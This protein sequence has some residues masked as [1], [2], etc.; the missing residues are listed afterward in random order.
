M[1]TFRPPNIDPALS[2]DAQQV[3]SAAAAKMDEWLTNAFKN[4]ETD[5]ASDLDDLQAKMQAEH[6][7]FIAEERKH[8]EAL[9]EQIKR[10]KSAGNNLTPL[11][12]EQ[13][14][15]MDQL[16]QLTTQAES[17]LKAREQRWKEFGN[18]TTSLAIN[19]VKTL[20]KGII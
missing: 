6:E 16:A 4:L 19:G 9:I 8:S 1:P 2:Q 12:P 5:L 17:E 15:V 10:L 13:K 7:Q 20:L 11:D 14:D 18:K 3:V